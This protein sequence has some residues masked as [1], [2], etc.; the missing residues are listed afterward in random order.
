ME[1][2]IGRSALLSGLNL[3]Q[4]IVERRNTVP[5]LGNVLIEAKD[6]SLTLAATDME[7]GMR[8]AMACECGNPGA[9]TLNAHKLFEIVR[10]T[11]A[12]EVSLRSL[13][14]DW[15]EMKCGR[16]R[17]KMMSLDPRSFPAMPSAAER[18]ETAAAGGTPRAELSIGAKVLTTMID[19]TIFA[20]SPDETRYNLSG[21]YVECP[22]P[23]TVRMAATD[24]HR[25]SM[26]DRPAPGFSMQTGAILPRK[27][28]NELR[29]LLDSGVEGNVI[30]SV[31]AQ[32]AWLLQGN[33]EISMRRVEGE[34]PDYR[35]VIPKDSKYRISIGRDALLSAIKR[36][37]IFSSERYHG[38]RLALTPGSL[39]VSSTSPELG[40]ASET[41]DVD[42]AGEEFSV[43]FNASYLMQAVTAVPAQ[44]EVLL[45]LTDEVSPGVL[46]TP[47]DS[48]YLYVVMPMR[49]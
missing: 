40:E 38:V 12:D 23:D 21:V 11:E 46:T 15:V 36:A 26:I 9:V 41:V 34:F 39:T 6:S 30:L 7:V 49:L 48:A 27:G 32:L 31:E 2:I 3:A 45:G 28:L 17:F 47:T 44:G 33:T 10:E 43:G 22:S 4:G 18:A 29:R 42:F 16:A 20:V 25:L 24:G 37:A 1:L 13:E 5:I 14:N 19:K 8:T 35:G